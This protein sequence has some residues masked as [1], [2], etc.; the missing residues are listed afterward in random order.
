LLSL[1]LYAMVLD[2]KRKFCR[3]CSL[4]CIHL[5]SF[6]K[7]LDVQTSQNGSTEYSLKWRLR[8]SG[9]MA[10]HQED[11]QRWSLSAATAN[12]APAISAVEGRER[13]RV[14]KHRERSGT[15]R[16]QKI[17]DVFDRTGRLDC[18]CCGR[19]AE[20]IYGPIGHGYCEV[21][22]LDA[23]AQG[24]RRTELGDLA[25]VC[26]C[27]HRMLHRLIRRGLPSS[28]ADLRQRLES[29]RE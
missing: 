24:E 4:F 15:L 27:C 2:R 8:R 7:T 20:R 23:I 13:L 3:S 26:A 9:R 10:S 22:H 1:T 21:H 16:T 12:A 14:H 29:P 28:I 11:R 6:S 25:V 17:D 19:D 18:E 5:K